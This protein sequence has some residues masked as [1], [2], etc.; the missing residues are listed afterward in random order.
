MPHCLALG[1]SRIVSKMLKTS[2]ET[3][4]ET[5]SLLAIAIVREVKI[6]SEWKDG[7]NINFFKGTKRASDQGI[8][9]GLKV[10]DHILKS[11][12]KYIE[13]HIRSVISVDDM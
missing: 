3:D 8:Y 2:L 4:S 9:R 7:Y 12:K 10:T 11:T 5:I 6:A 13:K 1:T